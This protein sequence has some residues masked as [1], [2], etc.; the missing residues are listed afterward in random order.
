MNLFFFLFMRNLFLVL[1]LLNI[2]SRVDGFLRWMNSVGENNATKM[3]G[4]PQCSY[5][6]ASFR[7]NASMHFVTQT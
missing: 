4:T 6:T 2:K 3:S 7:F 5:C 1:I